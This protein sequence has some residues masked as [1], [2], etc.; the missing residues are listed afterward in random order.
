M[1]AA[2]RRTALRKNEGVGLGAVGSRVFLK[3]C[4]FG[5]PGTVVQ[6]APLRRLTA[7]LL[8]IRVATHDTR[9]DMMLLE[10]GLEAKRR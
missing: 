1:D 3:G 8:W 9:Q 10:S 7:G 6:V 2:L 4:A 5:Q